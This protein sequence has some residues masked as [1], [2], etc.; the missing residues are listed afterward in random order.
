M[1]LFGDYFGSYL[2]EYDLSVLG[3]A[4]IKRFAVQKG[5]RELLVV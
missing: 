4:Q 5:K 1:E 2:S 3:G